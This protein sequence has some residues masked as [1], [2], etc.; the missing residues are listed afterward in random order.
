MNT[1]FYHHGD[2]DLAT[3]LLQVIY[4]ALNTM[5]VSHLDF[6]ISP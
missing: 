3:P 6:I 5:L 2:T 1:Q 4:V